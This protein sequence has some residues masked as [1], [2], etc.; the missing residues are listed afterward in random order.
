MQKA[1]QNFERITVSLPV[2]LAGEI[3]M[4]K[5]ELHLSKSEVLKTALEKFFQEH[6]RNKIMK[7]AEMMAGEYKKNKELT[8]LT[9]LD[10]EEF[11]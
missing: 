10:G 5:D 9:A 4:L 6:K 11:K 1:V 3:N 8:L 7:A 2:E